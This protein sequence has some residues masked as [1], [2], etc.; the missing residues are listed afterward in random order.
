MMASITGGLAS[1]E[2][3][4]EPARA[5][6]DKSY[7]ITKLMSNATPPELVE[8]FLIQYCSLGVSM[9]EPV[10]GWIRRAGVRC[11]E[12]GVRELGEALVCHAK[13][14]A[15]HHMMMI[16]DTRSLVARWNAARA[17]ALDAETFLLAPRPSGVERYVELHERTIAGDKP[18]G[19]IAIEYEIEL[20]SIRVGPPFIGQCVNKLGPDIT[21]CLSFVE[22]HVELDV[23]HTKLNLRQ[24]GNLLERHPDFLDTLVATG[25]AALEVYAQFMEDCMRRAEAVLS[26]LSEPSSAAHGQA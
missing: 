19:Q 5:R 8:L 9:T 25:K 23:G 15:G 4:L 6:F 13:H 18:F 1:Y 21:R 7:G 22:D 11:L 26:G 3:Q 14:E 24:L 20:M 16:R 17:P 12:V 2:E 10:E